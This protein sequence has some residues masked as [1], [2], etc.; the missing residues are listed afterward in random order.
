MNRITPANND[1]LEDEA[2]DDYPIIPS[3]FNPTMALFNSDDTE[4]NENENENEY[5]EST[6]YSFNT[7]PES[8]PT[9][10]QSLTPTTSFGDSNQQQNVNAN[11]GI[12]ILCK[13]LELT[14]VG[15]LHCYQLKATVGWC[16]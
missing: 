12:Q 11:Q 15:V 1:H 4:D 3:S 10:P 7:K 13:G 9:P 5:T 8:T 6:S 16:I 2:D 14:N